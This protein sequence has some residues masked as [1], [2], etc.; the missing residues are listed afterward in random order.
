MS[1][2]RVNHERLWAS[3]MEM[4]ALGQTP[5]GGCRRLALTDEDKQARDQFCDWAKAAGCNVTVDRMGNIFARREGKDTHAAPVMM[6]SHLD[7][8]P[9]GGK[10]DGALGV[11]SGIEVLR[12]L[13]ELSIRTKIPVEVAVWTNE[14]GSRFSPMTMG[15]SVF[16]D[17][18]GLD[19]ALD[20]ADGN[21]VT[22]A[23]ALMRIGY[24]GTAPVGGR[25]ISAYLELH[26]EQGPLL[27]ESGECIGVVNGSFN[28]RY[29][30]ATVKGEPAHVGPT[31]MDMRRDALVATAALTLEVERIGRSRGRKGRSNAPQLSVYPNVRGVIPAEV[32]LSCDV[33]HSDRNEM[34]VMEQ[35]LRAACARIASERGVEISLDQYFEF[36]PVEFDPAMTALVGET[37]RALELSHRNILT[38]AGH[39]AVP[40]NAI[41]PTAMIFV[42]SET[43][44]SHNEAE[45]STPGQCADG[46]DVLLNMVLKLAG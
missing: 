41:C 2:V 37:A 14:E 31:P 45:Y 21:G 30:V 13:E 6:G 18:Y 32:Q 27:R 35:E 26:I 7:T 4:G 38:V 36:G 23:Q 42:P 8:V 20:R 1:I 34:L 16:V 11:V 9:T 39:D 17:Q 40:M 5:G 44:I 43:G 15:S 12:R 28:A 10:F 46:A 19:A 29:F 33:R 3:L 25:E 22:V 24:A